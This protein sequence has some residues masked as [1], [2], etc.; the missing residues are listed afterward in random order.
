VTSRRPLALLVLGATAGIAAAAAGLLRAPA[1][2]RGALPPD[3]VARVNDVSIGREDYERMLE[4]VARDRREPLTDALRRQVLDRLV[5]EELLVQRGLSLG[6]AARDRKL[7]A[8]LT[9][10]VIDAVVAGEAGTPPSDAELERFYAEHRDFFAGPGHLRVRR[11]LVRVADGVGD[12]AALERARQAASQL[13]AGEAFDAVRG[14]LGDAEPAPL[15]DAALPPA[16][17]RDYLGPTALAATLRLAPGEVSEPVRSSD[18]YQVTQVVAREPG[19]D[20]PLAAVRPRVLDEYHRRA[21]DLALRRYLDDLRNK[22]DVT[23]A[24]GLP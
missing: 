17:L 19:P 15:P 14:A 10:A 24:E 8:D 1:G 2:P 18:G 3:A 21:A 22:A 12:A 4:A 5:D 6:L 20:G 13:R 16:K 9:R 7:R 23:V 11:L